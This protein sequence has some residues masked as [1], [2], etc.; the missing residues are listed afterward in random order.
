MQNAA[1]KTRDAA[2]RNNLDFGVLY[3]SLAS[4]IK[5]FSNRIYGLVSFNANIDWLFSM[6]RKN[7]EKRNSESLRKWFA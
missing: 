6:K 1:C 3:A 5:A 7:S 2:A 4:T